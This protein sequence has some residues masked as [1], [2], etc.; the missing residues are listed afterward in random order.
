MSGLDH[1]DGVAKDYNKAKDGCK[2]F[3][4]YKKFADIV[5]NSDE[6]NYSGINGILQFI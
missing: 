2:F 3:K 4:L 6:W 1:M 5:K